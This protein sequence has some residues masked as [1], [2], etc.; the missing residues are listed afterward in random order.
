MRRR[1]LCSR[2]GVVDQVER[3]LQSV[4]RTK[5]LDPPSGGLRR[6]PRD[7]GAEFGD[8]GVEFREFRA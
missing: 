6:Q 7:F 2:V 4:A 5:A 8:I 1:A 3:R